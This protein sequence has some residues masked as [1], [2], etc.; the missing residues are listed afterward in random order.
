MVLEM[1]VGAECFVCKRVVCT[2]F[3]TEVRSGTGHTTVRALPNRVRR[4]TPP[5]GT[6]CGSVVP[7]HHHILR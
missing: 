6:G 7:L 1:V 4:T 3:V 2:W 5:F